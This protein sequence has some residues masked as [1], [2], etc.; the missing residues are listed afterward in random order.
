LPESVRAAIE[1]QAAQIIKEAEKE[2][3]QIS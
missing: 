3:V 2:P 1:L